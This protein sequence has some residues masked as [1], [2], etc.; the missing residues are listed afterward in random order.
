MQLN[1]TLLFSKAETISFN[2]NIVMMKIWVFTFL[3]TRTI[4]TTKKFNW[5]IIV[6]LIGIGFLSIWGFQQHFLGNVRLE[7]VGGGNYASSN[8][9]A[10]A[11]VQFVPVFVALSFVKKWRYKIILL[12]VSIT[13][14]GVIVFT[15]SRAAFVGAA[16]AGL[17]LMLR[18]K[19]SFQFVIITLLIIGAFYYVAIN[20]AG[21]TERVS[22]GSME[23]EKYSERVILWKAAWNI[24][25]DHPVTGV[26]LQNFQFYSARYIKEELG[27]ERV[28]F[29]RGDAHNTFLLILAEGGF[30][31]FFLLLLMIFIF[32]KDIR[33]LRKIFNNNSEYTHLLIGI[34][35][36]MVAFLFAN[37]F[38]SMAY[39]ENFYWFLFLPSILK[40]II[41][42]GQYDDRR[43]Q[44]LKFDLKFR[45]G[46]GG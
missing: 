39:M 44:E 13:M 3:M 24:A 5:F 23:K 33:S 42:Q 27:A 11:V 38:H 46:D 7:E 16:I 25:K 43:I 26:G 10:A 31:A 21:Y 17:I 34:E 28:S 18:S 8:S 19:K 9:L 35:A 37:M 2:Y 22:P 40:S 30:G 15:E 12:L 29:S 20:V 32:F 14:I 6:N 1:S 36:G 45:D 41:H 4:N